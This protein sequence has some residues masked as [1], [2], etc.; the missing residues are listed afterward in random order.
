MKI[1]TIA[2]WLFIASVCVCTVAVSCP[3]FVYS[4]YSEKESAVDLPEEL[5]FHFSDFDLKSFE[6]VDEIVLN[7][8]NSS[9][10]KTQL[11]REYY[12]NAGTGEELIRISRKNDEKFIKGYCFSPLCNCVFYSDNTMKL[13][14]DEAGEI[15]CF[16][17]S[18]L[19]YFSRISVCKR[20]FSSVYVITYFDG[21]GERIAIES[22]VAYLNGNVKALSFLYDRHYGKNLLPLSRKK[23]D[24]LL[25]R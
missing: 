5:K 24:S 21:N 7:G 6:K 16:S 25:R 11:V 15:Y 2:L 13:F 8:E 4:G 3:R 10:E 17:D 22:R 1:R 19:K 18:R 23:F 12:Q 9:G 20:L 14:G